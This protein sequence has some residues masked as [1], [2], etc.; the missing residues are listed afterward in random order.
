MSEYSAS[1]R[2]RI[3]RRRFLVEHP[4]CECPDPECREPATEVHHVDG[5]GL[6]GP[7]AYDWDNLQALTKRCHSRITASRAPRKRPAEQHP[8]RLGD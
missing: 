8:G 6:D 3:L 4:V 5:L 2:W 7:R 1:P